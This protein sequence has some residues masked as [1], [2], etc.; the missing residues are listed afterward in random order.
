MRKTTLLCTLIVAAVA[1][2]TGGIA[3]ADRLQREAERKSTVT[4]NGQYSGSLEGTIWLDGKR[5]VITRQTALHS[6]ED[7]RIRSG[8]HVVRRPLYVSGVM[9]RDG[10]IRANLIVVRA[11]A[12]GKR[13]APTPA[14]P[15]E[16]R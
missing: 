6:V 3:R 9:E 11:Q 14:D 5:V 1:I 2:A 16:G 8:Y 13:Q 7:G 10:V 15:D 4:V 12:S